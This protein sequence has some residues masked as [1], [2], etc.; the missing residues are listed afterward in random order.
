ML[1]IIWERLKDQIFGSSTI[2]I[3]FTW[4]LQLMTV[5][6]SPT[7]VDKYLTA[8][9]K[10][11]KRHAH[12]LQD[13]RELYSKLL[14][15]SSAAPQG[16][17][18]LTSLEDMLST[19]GAKPFL[20]HRAGKSVSKDLDWWS[21]LL[22]SGGVVRNIYPTSQP[23]NPLAFSDASSGIGIGIVI[24]KFWRAWRLIPGWQTL[25]GK[26]DIGWAEAIGFIRKSLLGKN[27]NNLR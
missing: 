20:P 25:N 1:G 22:Q 18:Y 8:I 26:R 19:N 15:T 10:W 27:C 3:G 23:Q 2:D 13:V 4:N 11:R 5:A 14:H 21:D 6:L 12:V 17:A 7:K 24:G 9:H 16:R